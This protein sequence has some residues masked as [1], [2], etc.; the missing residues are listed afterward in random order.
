ML[1]AKKLKLGW[2]LAQQIAAAA[3]ALVSLIC[4]VSA[5]VNMVQALQAFIQYCCTQPVFPSIHSLDTLPISSDLMV[6]A[7]PVQ[8]K[9]EESASH[10]SAGVA[11]VEQV[12]ALK[13]N[14]FL[15]RDLILTSNL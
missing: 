15:E 11:I 7:Q 2:K 5:Q 4:P 14:S 13:F 9:P 6:L 10:Q 3:T 8:Q 12:I 1:V